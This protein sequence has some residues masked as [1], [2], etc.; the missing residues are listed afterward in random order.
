MPPP[1][2]RFVPFISADFRDA[3][4][5]KLP[6]PKN[7]KEEGVSI[8]V[9]ASQSMNASYPMFVTDDGI[10]IDDNDEQLLKALS[11][12]IL[13][14]EGISMEANDVHSQNALLS[15]ISTLPK[16]TDVSEWHSVNVDH[17]LL[18][19]FGKITSVTFFLMN[20]LIASVTS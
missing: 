17:S 2:A 13:T 3:Q 15:I 20:V 18:I 10:I 16:S 14:V 11:P 6:E 12:M 1:T 19:E 7:F 8:E 5:L 9:S 4:Y